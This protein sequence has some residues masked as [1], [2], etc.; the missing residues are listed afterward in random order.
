VFSNLLLA[1]A[2]PNLENGWK[3][4][5][6]YDGSHLD[7]VNVMNGNLMAHAP[8]TPDTPPAKCLVCQFND[9][10][11]VCN[12]PS[13]LRQVCNWRKGRAGVIVLSTPGI[14]QSK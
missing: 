14:G 9:W 8:L 7:T 11:A 1:Q 13:Q 12:Q 3:P 2:A 5:D 6:S 10:Q 4:Y